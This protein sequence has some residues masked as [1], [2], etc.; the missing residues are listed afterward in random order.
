MKRIRFSGNHSGVDQ[1]SIEKI[2]EHLRPLCKQVNSSWGGGY[3]DVYASLSLPSDNELLAAVQKLISEKQELKPSVQVII[4]MGGSSLGA[5]AIYQALHTTVGAPVYFLDTLDSWYCSQVYKICE[6]VLQAGE[7]ILITVISKSGTTTETIANAQLFM[8]L[9]AE[10]N[11]PYQE[12]VVAITDENSPLWKK[13]QK[14]GISCLA[15]PP[16]VGGR[17]SVFS[18]VGLFPL[19]MMGVDLVA[20]RDGAQSMKEPCSGSAIIN[21]P[22]AISAAIVYEQY[23]AGY[24]IHDTFIFSRLLRGIADWYRQLVGESLGKADNKQGKR[25]NVGITPTVSVGPEDLH[26][27]AQLYLGG[28]YNRMTTFLSMPHK[29]DLIVA[30]GNP[31]DDLIPM[32]RGKSFGQIM[33]AIERGTHRAYEHD[34]RPYMMIALPELSAYTIGQFMQLQMVQTMYL[35]FLL[36]INPFDQPQVE[37]YKKETRGILTHE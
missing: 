24:V 18:A 10:Y 3:K 13:A 25:V 11:K 32:I 16:L 14:E 17:Y 23:R 12:Y 26:S 6:A 30:T 20:L 19:G 22:A 37:L 1:E 36:D 5:R 35:G 28:P 31:F 33:S 34:K 29:D 7:E 4:G 8:K 21:N 2:G 27:V 15:V 9:L